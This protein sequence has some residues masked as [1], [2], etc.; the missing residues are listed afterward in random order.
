MTRFR[1]GVSLDRV[2]RWA[3]DSPRVELLTHF[4]QAITE[5]HILQASVAIAGASLWF[6]LAFGDGRFLVLLPAAIV[7]VQRFRQLERDVVPDD[8]D[9]WL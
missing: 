7:A 2:E 8:D 1:I 4:M 9:D 3:A 5:D 6:T